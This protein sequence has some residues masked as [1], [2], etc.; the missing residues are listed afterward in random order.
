MSIPPTSLLLNGHSLDKVETFEYLGV[1]D[2]SWGEHV[3]STCAKAKKILGLL[4][5]QFYKHTPSNAMLQLYLSL[6]RSHLDYA[7]STCLLT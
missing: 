5:R 7:A 2:L 1:H 3:P 6:V 4:Y